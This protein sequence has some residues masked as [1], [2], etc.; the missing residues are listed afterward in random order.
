MFVHYIWMQMHA[1]QDV[2]DKIYNH[3][4]FFTSLGIPVKV[5]TQR[6]IIDL[7]ASKY[8]MYLS[9]YIKILNTIQ[10]CDIARCLSH[11]RRISRQSL[12]PRRSCSIVL[13]THDC[14]RD[15]GRHRRGWRGRAVRHCS[16]THIL[17]HDHRQG[18][19]PA[20]SNRRR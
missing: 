8:S 11:Y 4:I 13:Q 12:C 16:S 7:I 2:F 15:R 14:R 9:R 3:R 19:H 5:W 17:P 20:E 18:T 1:P 10:R 6:E